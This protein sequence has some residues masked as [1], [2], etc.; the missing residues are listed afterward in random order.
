MRNQEERLKQ[1]V[2][3]E[4]LARKQAE[5][6]LEEKSLRLY[7]TN[8]ALEESLSTYQSTMTELTNVFLKTGG[9]HSRNILRLVEKF[10]DLMNVEGGGY[11]PNP[12]RENPTMA[13]TFPRDFDLPSIPGLFESCLRTRLEEDNQGALYGFSTVHAEYTNYGVVA[14][15]FRTNYTPTALDRV[16]LEL[17]SHAIG[18]EA[19]RLEADVENQA[20]E[21]RYRGLFHASID[22]ILIHKLNGAITEAS[23]SSVS[24]FGYSRE[25]LRTMKITRMVDPASFAIAKNAFRLVRNSGFCRYEANFKR[26]DGSTFPAE[27]YGRLFE[28]NGQKQIYGILRDI[29]TRKQ[30]LAAAVER[31]RKF[32]AVFESSLDGIILHD[33]EGRILDINRAVERMFSTPREK[34]LG[35]NVSTILA[36]GEPERVGERIAH[37][38]ERGQ[39]R[40]Q[41]RFLRPSGE[42]FWTEATGVVFELGGKKLIQGIIRDITEQREQEARTLQAREE[43]EQANAAKSLF[44]ATMSHEIR[45]PLNGILGFADL[46]SQMDLKEEAQE[47]IGIIQRSG[48]LLANLLNDLLDLSQ[49]ESGGLKLK[50]ATFDIRQLVRDV[51]D[52]HQIKARK[53]SISITTHIAPEV[54]ALIIGDNTRTLQVV[55]N[56]VGNA[57]KYIPS[58]E[59]SVELGVTSDRLI[60]T[61]KDNGPGFPEEMK[62]KLFETFY[63]VDRSITKKTGGTGLGLAVCREIVHAMGGKIH[64]DSTPGEGATFKFWIPLHTPTDQILPPAQKA[65]TASTSDL[66]LLIVEDHEINAR[67][68][69][70]MLSKLGFQHQTAQHGA[71][72]LEILRTKDDFAAILMDVR[73]PVMDGLEAARRIRAG[74]AGRKAADLPI[75]AVTANA[76]ESDRESCQAAG[77]PYFISKP[78]RRP[79]LN[80]VLSK[81]GVLR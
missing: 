48:D 19:E 10:V 6:L 65:T 34:L 12:S 1:R 22:G 57:V 71:E 18:V 80:E 53:K 26:S 56:L 42:E 68:L 27:V 21:E 63:Q 46:L 54:P 40:F 50:S 11:F 70:I 44:L 73:M 31:E 37:V 16:I 35:I 24:M 43:A 60:V 25:T 79:H 36:P 77:M 47:A 45:T 17:A 76:M 3:R 39:A 41:V 33:L 2:A 49:I 74:E 32:R 38:V 30:T 28:I 8:R 62:E 67:L 29:T 72:A 52:A 14:V 61:V 69:G 23:D 5:D 58:G 9:D 55:S 7:E 51:V 75:I 81:I 78:I 59:V 66:S 20:Q 4:K 13:Q 15:R 64:A